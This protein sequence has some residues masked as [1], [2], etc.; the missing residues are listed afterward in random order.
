MEKSLPD[1]DQPTNYKELTK[2]RLKA[3]RV[4]YERA[5]QLGSKLVTVT[6]STQHFR[7]VPTANDGATGSQRG[8]I[9]LESSATTCSV[10]V[11]ASVLGDAL[12]KALDRCTLTVQLV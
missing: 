9:A 1:V 5:F 12:V 2:A 7:F 8:F 11:E 3:A 6:R 4:R 10:S